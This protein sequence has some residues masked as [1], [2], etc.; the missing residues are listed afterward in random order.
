MKPELK[1]LPASIKDYPVI[2][3][4]ARFYLYDMSKFCHHDASDWAIP[5]D[6]LYEWCMT[7][8]NW[9]AYSIEGDTPWRILAYRQNHHQ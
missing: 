7:Q 6:G 2:Q 8:L 4:M 5:E 1:I 3:N 9:V